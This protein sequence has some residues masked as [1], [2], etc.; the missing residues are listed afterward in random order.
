MLYQPDLMQ[1][2]ELCGASW[3]RHTRFVDQSDP[4]GARPPGLHALSDGD[5]PRSILRGVV[6]FGLL[7]LTVKGVFHAVI[8][9]VTTYFSCPH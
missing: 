7:L 8:D 2:D 5:T 6:C 9:F 1:R 3:A 4:P